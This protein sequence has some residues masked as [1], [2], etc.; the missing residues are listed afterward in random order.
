MARTAG[1]VFL[2]FV[3]VLVVSTLAR[4]HLRPPMPPIDDA[5]RAHLAQVTI[6]RDTW[7]VPHIHGRTDADAAFG[8]AYAHSE[9][10]W[11]TIQ[12]V[13]AAT[14]GQLGLL[15]LDGTS[16][17][18][19]YY[20]HFVRASE[21]AAEA[22]DTIDPATRVVLEGY[23][24]GLNHYARMHPDEADT[25]LLPVR[26]VDIAAGFAH[27]LSF[28]VGVPAVMKAL[29]DGKLTGVGDKI[30]AVVPELERD[31]PGSNAYAVTASRSADGRARLVINSHQPWEGPV[32]WYEAHVR[33]DEG[34]D[35][36]G[37]L[38]PGS[39]FVLHGHNAHLGWAHTVNAPDV[40]DVYALVIDP[41]HPDHYQLD[42]Q[43]KPIE[44]R[45]VSLVLDVGPF[46]LRVTQKVYSSVHGPVLATD[47][48]PFAVRWAGMDR[49]VH[50]TTQWYRM[51][52]ARS[53]E[54]WQAAMR[55]HAIP[56]FHT[57]YADAAHI[58][59]VYN[60]L[61]YQRA[62]GHDYR[63]VLPGDRASLVTTD[64]LPY[65]QLPQVTDPASG[66]VQACNSAPWVATLGPEAPVRARFAAEHGIED[67]VTNRTR[68]SLALLGGTE[69]LSREAVHALKWDRRYADTSV[70]MQQVVAPLVS[71][72]FAPATDA[73]RR[74][75][76]L[77]RAWD[78]TATATSAAATLAILSLKALLPELRAEGDPPI[79]DAPAALRHTLAWLTE[80]HGRTEVPLGEVQVL[81]RGK[82]ELG[83]G[84][85]PD[86][87]NAIYVKR[88]EGQLVG[89]Q[90][91]S[92]VMLVEWTPDGVR[93]ESVHQ[94]GS[95]SREGSPHYAD[96]APL[97]AARRL[98]PVW[99]T[100]AELEAN[101]ARVYRPGE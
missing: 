30:A 11:P 33:S 16:M 74:A 35:M 70:T 98:K 53:L 89:T 51:N 96:Q 56:M 54:E 100:D 52:K 67:V 82:V 7:G 5:T 93:S 80:H 44:E 28:M 8:L 94:Y 46:D 87:M 6:R 60:A 78:L 27:K 61:L 69:P 97:F 2:G 22:W 26:G 62:P 75:V 64:Y 13:M 45:S 34:W 49:G 38:F 1:R 83:L 23:A 86:L 95:S 18:V 24:R 90:G 21:Q 10:D 29:H 58:H 101:A 4:P 63:A 88:V 50:A 47:H 85:G 66:F 12:G 76:E 14:R 15:R 36:S 84:G 39:P 59:Y 65:E 43:W 48:G 55:V 72:G 3:V 81:R 57:V 25:R 92:L 40:V 68:R 31:F 37:G 42:G 17:V 20:A 73:E 9:D 99:R 41:E 91:D 77:L 32:A 79:A 19:D 71:G